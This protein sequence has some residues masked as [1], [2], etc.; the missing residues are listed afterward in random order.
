MSHLFFTKFV[1]MVTTIMVNAPLLENSYLIVQ[2]LS[3]L[4]FPNKLLLVINLY[5]YKCLFLYYNLVILLV[6]TNIH[7][8]KPTPKLLGLRII[9][10]SM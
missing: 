6:T 5:K 9:W 3:L 10:T 2:I 8:G 1:E 4:R 7:K